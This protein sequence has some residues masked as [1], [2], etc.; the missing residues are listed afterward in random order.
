MQQDFEHTI[1][2]SQLP[3]FS[4][5]LQA[6]RNLNFNSLSTPQLPKATLA[7]ARHPITRSWY[8]TLVTNTTKGL[9]LESTFNASLGLDPMVLLGILQNYKTPKLQIREW[10]RTVHSMAVL[11]STP[12]LQLALA[13]AKSSVEMAVLLGVTAPKIPPTCWYTE[14]QSRALAKVA[15]STS[16][17]ESIVCHAP[18]E[19][20]SKSVLCFF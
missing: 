13:V 15:T 17:F 8:S 14:L 2:P 16:M 5:R 4:P 11:T 3:Q 6:P 20:T 10:A 19:W 18:Y 7:I 9:T 1:S 12:S